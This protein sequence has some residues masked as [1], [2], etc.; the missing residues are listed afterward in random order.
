MA[1]A[2]IRALTE[3]LDTQILA[4]RDRIRGAAGCPVTLIAIFESRL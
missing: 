4:L 1:L 3:F 2:E